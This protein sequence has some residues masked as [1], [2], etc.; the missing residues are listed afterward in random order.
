LCYLDIYDPFVVNYV[1]YQCNTAKPIIK[2]HLPK[3]IEFWGTLHTP[4]WL[5]DIIADGVKVPF[6]TTPPRIFRSNNKSAVHKENIEWVRSS[7]KEYIEYGFILPVDTTPHCVMPLQVKTGTIKNSLIYDMTDL[8]AFVD[9]NKFSLESWPQM[10]AYANS[11]EFG[12]KFDLKNITMRLIL[13]LS[14]T[15][16]LDSHMFWTIMRIRSIL[17]GQRYRLAITGRRS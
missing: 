14:F 11:A 12:I 10:V 7:I 9:T 3:H 13:I 5:L 17:F 6:L 2:G 8:N 4:D 16:I 1:Q 15:R